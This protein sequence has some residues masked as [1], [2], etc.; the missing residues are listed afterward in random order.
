M[1]CEVSFDHSLGRR[2]EGARWAREND[3]EAIAVSLVRE[4][5]L[6]QWQ[7]SCRGGPA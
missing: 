7:Q 4:G 3:E 2:L 5:G 1:K 6:E